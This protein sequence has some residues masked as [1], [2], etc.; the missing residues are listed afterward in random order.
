MTGRRSELR[1]HRFHDRFSADST[2]GTAC[3]RHLLAS[4]PGE[5]LVQLLRK[6]ALDEHEVT[7]LAP[8]ASRSGCYGSRTLAPSQW[9]AQHGPR[10]KRPSLIATLDI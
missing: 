6:L 5:R 10:P 4:I 9:P 2:S 3:E 7:R 8:P 1:G